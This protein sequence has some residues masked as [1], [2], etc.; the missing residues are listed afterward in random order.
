MKTVTITA[1]MGNKKLKKEA[2]QPETLKEAL[3]VYG[4]EDR[5]LSLAW[6]SHVIDV[7]RGMR[8]GDPLDRFLEKHP[9]YKGRFK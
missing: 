9:Q 5:L 1:T 3:E 8:E 7:Q 2:K 4:S 6:R